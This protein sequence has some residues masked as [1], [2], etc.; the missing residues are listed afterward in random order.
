M[1]GV[2]TQTDRELVYWL[3]TTM[4]GWFG[5][6][7]LDELDVLLCASLADTDEGME[8]EFLEIHR[9]A[10][11]D[12]LADRP[13]PSFVMRLLDEMGLLPFKAP[14]VCLGKGVTREEAREYLL[15]PMP[16]PVTICARCG[17]D[18]KGIPLMERDFRRCPECGRVYPP[19]IGAR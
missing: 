5:R 19:R 4:L 18:L 7:D 6:E 9:A 1:P 12:E 2:L 16:G 10:V 14:R 13:R 8:R 15:H 3:A 17:Y 11:A